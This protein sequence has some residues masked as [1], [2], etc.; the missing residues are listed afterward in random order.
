M[1]FDSTDS[2]GFGFDSLVTGE[3]DPV[4]FLLEGKARIWGNKLR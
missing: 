1:F 3:R 2:L 4:W